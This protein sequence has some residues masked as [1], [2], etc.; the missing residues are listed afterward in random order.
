MCEH[1]SG[2]IPLLYL[3]NQESQQPKWLLPVEDVKILDEIHEIRKATSK[4]DPE[5]RRREMLSAIS[6]PL[7]DLIAARSEDCI[8]SS[9][10]C[11]FVT[12]VLLSGIG[13]KAA[14]LRSVAALAESADADGVQ[15]VLQTPHAGRL[16]KTLVQ[17][18]RYD[19]KSKSVALVDP[20]LAFGDMLYDSLIKS[21]TIEAWATGANSWVIVALLE[22][23]EFTKG[24]ELMKIMR[25]AHLPPT[26]DNAGTKVVLEKLTKTKQK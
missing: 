9:F 17:G 24:D 19:K 23:P 26:T 13:E 3:M 25:K 12:E 5:L 21:G 16:L 2:R 8:K 10:G 11:Q 7:L 20:P 1:L 6:Q 15:A 18:G 4:K 22:S 14:A